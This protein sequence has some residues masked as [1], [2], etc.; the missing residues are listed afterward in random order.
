MSDRHFTEAPSGKLG[1]P[2]AVFRVTE[3][4]EIYC[5]T[6]S[7]D[8]GGLFYHWLKGRS[9]YCPGHDCPAHIHKNP[10]TW[11]GY[12]PVEIWNS[13]S[14]MWRRSVLEI[15]ESLE[16]DFRGVFGRGQVWRIERAK[17]TSKK[18][19]PIVGRLTEELPENLVPEPF[20]VIPV[21]L[22]LYHEY[23]LDLSARNPLPQRQLATES[24]GKPPSEKCDRNEG[25]EVLTS[26]QVR[27]KLRSVLNKTAAMPSKNGSV[28]PSDNKNGQ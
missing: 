9:V 13:S 8:Y 24:P 20:D 21:L 3:G 12:C 18:K 16:L 5:R 11:K 25:L 4:P 10:K 19:T 2:I 15:S 14:K 23:S 1:Y 27:E 28:E 6:L 7:T 17:Q 26:A 22:H